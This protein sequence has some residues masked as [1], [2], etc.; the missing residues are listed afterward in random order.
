MPDPFNTPNRTFVTEK[1]QVIAPKR[2]DEL[3]STLYWE[4]QAGDKVFYVD[5]DTTYTLGA[6]DSNS[7]F[8]NLQQGFIQG[9]LPG[10]TFT[11]STDVKVVVG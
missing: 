7:V 10:Q 3:D 6:S 2:I 8:A 4:P 1:M 9:I 5:N 11:F